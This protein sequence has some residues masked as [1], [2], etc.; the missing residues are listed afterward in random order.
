MG[1]RNT[2]LGQSDFFFKLFIIITKKLLNSSRNTS[3]GGK[4]AAKTQKIY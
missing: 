2:F 3:F 1:L 4:K